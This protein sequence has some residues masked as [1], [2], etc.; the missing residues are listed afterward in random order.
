MWA[1]A[2]ATGAGVGAGAGAD[3]AGV[4]GAD[5]AG[6]DEAGADSAGADATGAGAGAL[7]WGRGGT[8]FAL[9]V[10]SDGIGAAAGKPYGIPARVSWAGSV[11]GPAAVWGSAWVE[12]IAWP[13]SKKSTNSTTAD[14]S[15]ERTRRRSMTTGRM[16]VRALTCSIRIMFMMRDTL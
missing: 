3:G 11:C 13:S 8:G 7:W 10:T 14:S 6:A 2:G 12:R 16:R 9:K 15:R 5:S 4:A 1:G